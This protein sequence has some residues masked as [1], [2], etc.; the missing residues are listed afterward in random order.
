MLCNVVHAI[1]AAQSGQAGPTQRM[2]GGGRRARRT[3]ASAPGSDDDGS[4]VSAGNATWDV[5][6]QHSNQELLSIVD[7]AAALHLEPHAF[8]GLSLHDLSMLIPGTAPA[9][10]LKFRLA[11]T[12]PV[13]SPPLRVQKSR[14][15]MTRPPGMAVSAFFFA[16]MFNNG[17]SGIAND[18]I[19]VWFEVTLVMAT[20]LFSLALS[21]TVAPP[22]DCN[23]PADADV[24][25][26]LLLADQILWSCASFM[27]WVGAFL[28]WSAFLV[29]VVCSAEDAK[30]FFCNNIRLSS[31]GVLTVILGIFLFGPG[32]ALRVWIVS[33]SRASQYVVVGVMGVLIASLNVAV[34]VMMGAV[35]CDTYYEVFL[36][37]LGGFGL[38][39]GTNRMREAASGEW[40]CR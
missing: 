26:T 30:H 12:T 38:L 21:L 14:K 3:A 7:A 29:V 25:A 28:L 18:R 2:I 27:L 4:N 23:N 10:L 33:T 6:R 8:V 16:N 22:V 19:A 37:L 39:P 5:M 17:P 9:M 31:W 1:R 13:T 36:A 40:G 24:C 34:V 32:I 20:L 11:L 15:G 35:G